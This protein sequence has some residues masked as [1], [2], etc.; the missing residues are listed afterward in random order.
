MATEEQAHQLLVQA[1][2]L[3]DEL[4]PAEA[5]PLALEAQRI[6]KEL[7]DQPGAALALRLV[8]AARLEVGELRPD[9]AFD[10][11]K[12][13][14]AKVRRS[15]KDGKRAD[16]ILQ[17]AMAEALLAKVQPGRALRAVA[18]ARAFFEREDDS[19]TVADILCSIIVPA[20]LARKEGDRAVNASND[21][22][23]FAQKLTDSRFEAKAWA[24]AGAA[25]FAAQNQDA[26]EASQKAVAL[27]GSQ[28]KTAQE[29]LAILT[30]ARGQVERKEAQ[31]GL[32]AARQALEAA[33]AAGLW[34]LA[35]QA[36]EVL[37]EAELLA[38]S[39][40]V[41]LQ[42]AQVQIQELQQG[43]GA[44]GVASAMCAAVVA[45]A[46]LKGVDGALE[47]VKQYVEALRAAGDKKGEARMLHKLATM[48]PFPDIALNSAQAA[49]ALTQ[50]VGDA[51]EEKAIKNTLTGI[52]VAKGKV[53][54]SP[55]RKEALNLLSD[56]SRELE[57]RDAERF[58]D[59]SKDLDG[60]WN[61]LNQSDIDA[62]LRKVIAKDPNAYL[63]F[64]KE[65]GAHLGNGGASIPG[66]PQKSQR[67]GQSVRPVPVQTLYIGFRMSGLSYGPRFRCCQ[68]AMKKMY[69]PGS[70]VSVIELPGC[71]DDW[72]R[73]LG[74][75]SSLL[76]CSLQCGASAGHEV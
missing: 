34:A 39:P 69:D 21:A 37:V 19:E 10:A 15:A 16:A 47:T 32:A 49:L 50:K 8:Q 52:Y 1:R 13:E 66:A 3:I 29:V 42:A 35:G 36:V 74:F 56:L 27:F 23:S 65:H 60:L 73:E 2:D 67:S 6:F 9:D 63:A 70:A 55:N 33:K 28:G 22:L 58:K 4:Q 31:L 62:A 26:Q 40:S 44:A 53:D 24:A 30:M 12:D 48:S 68:P 64:L 17:V 76:D 61:A 59:I 18:E 20:F 38:S 25:R 7:K 45:Q 54:K 57:K 43:R 75:S 14:A 46:A 72:E 41:A 71:A 51:N 11:A 5:L